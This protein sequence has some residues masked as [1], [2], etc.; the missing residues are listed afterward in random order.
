[1]S[2]QVFK[3]DFLASIIVFLVALPLCIGVSVACGLP[4]YTGIVSAIIGGIIV[5]WLSGS[6]LQVSGPAAGL[7]LVVV[8]IV[9]SLG[10]GKLGLVV[11][12]AGIFQILF[13]VFSLGKWFRAISPAIIEGML[14]GIGITIFLTQFHVML[15]STPKNGF[16]AN[17]QDLLQVLYNAVFPLD[18][19]Q[20]HIAGSIGLLTIFIIMSWK[21]IPIK[22]I[23][24][25]PSAL[26]AI[27]IA[28]SVVFFFDLPIKHINVSYDFWSDV[29]FVDIHILKS[30]FEWPVIMNALMMT[31]VASAETLLT[32]TAID[33]L[34]PLSKTD[35][36]KEVFAQGI[37]NSLSG[38]FGALPVTGVM[39]RSAANI[40]A[41]AQ[42]R[43]STI[44]HGVW[45]LIFVS[46]LPFVLGY[47]PTSSL[48]A[49]LVYTGI[50]LIKIEEAKFL[51]KIS[52]PEFAVYIITVLG[53]L[54]T[55]LFEG[56]VLGFVSAIAFSV[57]KTL[58]LKIDIKKVPDENKVVV[59]LSGNITFV[60]L[61][62]LIDILES[63]EDEPNI[64]LCAEKLY[65]IDHACVDYI[66]GWEKEHA[67]E[68]KKITI[69]WRTIR[70]THP[71]FHW[72][73]FERKN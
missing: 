10:V 6:S 72:R 67:S 51:Y 64:E 40:D 52:R 36:N 69:D 37:G 3:K 55:N 9:H 16:I 39:V 19:S 4:I 30:L 47:I 53:I 46:F 11:F 5:G 18:G 15:D 13:G 58:K 41:G 73:E 45:I 68:D 60:Q 20:H 22:K 25:I 1:M 65:F 28:S 61:P 56:I 33:K 62:Y 63:L 59:K 34:S 23:R 66:Q 35:Y 29:H 32:S 8:D 54:F 70:R 57:Y 7:I 2:F 26:A 71:E 27:I 12:L 31:F 50:K 43:L 14:S 24:T 42:T 48:A 38:L 17:I 44:L 49:I 21:F